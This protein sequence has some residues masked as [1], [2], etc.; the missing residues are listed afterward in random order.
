MD[1]RTVNLPLQDTLIRPG[2]KRR[3]T[4]EGLPL[5]KSPD[6]RGDLVVE[7][8]VRFPERLT[9]DAKN[10]IARVLPS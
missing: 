5:P 1:N 3:I 6:R 4:G 8:E 7:F 2:M 10:T 9:Q